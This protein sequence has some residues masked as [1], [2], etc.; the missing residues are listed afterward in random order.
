MRN[1]IKWLEKY[2]LTRRLL[3][4]VKP[5]I[6]RLLTW[7]KKYS[8]EVKGQ[9][10]EVF[11]EGDEIVARIAESKEE[12]QYCFYLLDSKNKTIDKTK[13]STDTE[14]RFAVEE[15]GIYWVKAYCKS[16]ME[17][18][19]MKSDLVDFYN[20]D[21]KKSFEEFCNLTNGKETKM[22]PLALC[23]MTD[24][25]KDFAVH[26]SKKA[27]MISDKFLSDNEFQSTNCGKNVE[28]IAA[29][30]LELDGKKVVFSGHMKS[31][32]TYVSG[33]KDITVEHLPNSENIGSY[34]YALLKN[35]N[36]EIGSDY[37]G[38]GKLYYYEDVDEFIVANNYHMMLLMM[39]DLHIEGKL[40]VEATVAMLCKQGQA[41]QQ[42]M[43]REREIEN[44]YLMPVDEKVVISN[45][46]WKKVKKEISEV[47]ENLSAEG[48]A[49][50][51]LTKGVDE[52]QENI[53][54][55]LKDARFDN[56]I[57]DV[58]GG[59][60]SRVIY[61]SASTLDTYK[62]KY[63]VRCLAN[64]E[65]FENER[66]DAALACKLNTVTQ[67]EYLKDECEYEY[68]ELDKSLEEMMSLGML[69]GY[70]YPYTTEEIPRHLVSN[71]NL[72]RLNGSYGEVTC[73][74]YYTRNMLDQGNGLP[75][76]ADEL[77]TRVVNKMGILSAKSY[78]LLQNRMKQ[79]IEKIPGNSWAEKWELHYLYYRNRLH[80][81]TV[82]EDQKGNVLSWGALQS[83]ALFKYKHM[84]YGKIPGVEEQLDILAKIDKR[85]VCTP[86]DKE[87]D[88]VAR[89][90]YV[91]KMQEKDWK[92]DDKKAAEHKEA[93][94]AS[95][96]LRRA[97]EITNEKLKNDIQEY[98]DSLNERITN[99]L[100]DLLAYGEVI[101]N[102]IVMPAYYAVQH[103]VF[104]EKEKMVLYLK[105]YT[106]LLQLRIFKED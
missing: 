40:D 43:F 11:L 76:D 79:E 34:T 41:F 39:K 71:K 50:A 3:C 74:A 102:E 75:Q 30:C 4:I 91:S 55:V 10:V 49:E 86:F 82:W 16:G 27:K 72:I 52:V 28:I 97:Q 103:D 25:Y 68:K 67:Y 81:D 22:N 36:V 44:T 54:V 7:M 23:K 80:F 15:S 2:A 32:E 65:S 61:G 24:P 94:L 17:T 19:T 58:T 92:Y 64:P 63:R 8:K 51:L 47:L 101:K 70:Y 87:S 77:V 37:F 98:N 5:Y 99:V 100:H 83:K 59:L 6:K 106:V 90:K 69:S 38:T 35:N 60:D 14:C 95:P 29:S 1:I 66:G 84:T 88:E 21:A 48:D 62:D 105:L 85:M 78:N 104:T 89:V 56:V 45:S 9:S 13:Y 46:S 26:V 31:D 18:Y 96:C 20:A 53:E 73:R 12:Q 33:E 93:L 42:T 57:L